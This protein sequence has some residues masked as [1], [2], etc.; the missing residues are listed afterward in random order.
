MCPGVYTGHHEHDL[1]PQGE[2]QLPV[3]LTPTLPGCEGGVLRIPGTR[4]VPAKLEEAGV[5]TP[6]AVPVRSPQPL[7][8]PAGEVGVGAG[9]HPPGPWVHTLAGQ[10]RVPTANSVW[11]QENESL[12]Q[13]RRTLPRGLVKTCAPR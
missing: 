10:G 11:S 1:Q 7:Q 9:H 5:G 12:Y 3:V 8:A 6:Q 2:P 4:P 13:L